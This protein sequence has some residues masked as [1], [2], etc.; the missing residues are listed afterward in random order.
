MVEFVEA[1]TKIPIDSIV[2]PPSISPQ[3]IAFLAITL[4]ISASFLIKRILE[5][6][7]MLH[8]R[9]FWMALAMFIYFVSVTSM[10]DN[11]I[12]KML[13]FLRGGS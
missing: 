2:C 12:C 9:S 13:M 10:M 1:K 5:G 4:L 3:Q 11:I 7:T 8:D 6:D